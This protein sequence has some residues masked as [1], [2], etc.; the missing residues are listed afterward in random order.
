MTADHEEPAV[1]RTDDIERL[2]TEQC[3][4]LLRT[5]ELGRLAIRR[6]ETVDIF[7][8]NYRMHDDK[9]YFRSAPGS[10]MVDLTSNPHVAFEIDGRSGRRVWS[11]VVHGIATRL[12]SDEEIARSGIETLRTAHPSDKFNYVAITTESVS[13]RAFT[14]TSRR[15]NSGSIVVFGAI[16]VALIAVAGILSQIL[17][18]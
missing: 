4:H 12:S 6:D 14:G 10:K 5:Q 18:R 7:P 2:D 8:V 13:G 16:V 1:K 9:L 17:T 15:W 11:V 3:R